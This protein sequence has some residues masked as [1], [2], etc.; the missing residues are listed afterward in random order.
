[1]LAVVTDPLDILEKSVAHG[2]IGSLKVDKRFP[3]LKGKEHGLHCI[4]L[5]LIVNLII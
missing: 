1:M 3:V 5:D 4:T 2:K